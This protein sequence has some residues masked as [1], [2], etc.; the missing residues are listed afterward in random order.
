MA[1][2]TNRRRFLAG[3][4][5][6]G[7]ALTLP[8]LRAFAQDTPHYPQLE[9]EGT[10]VI[11]T[12]G[13]STDERIKSFWMTEFEKEYGLSW[14]TTSY[15][16][17]AK[18]E[19]M[20]RIGNVE[21]DLV[22]L[23]GTQMN[24]AISKDLLRP[25]DYELLYSVVPQ[26]ELNQDV[27]KEYGIGSVAFSTVMG[28]DTDKFE[29]G[30]QTW[31]EFFD[32]E[33]FPGR[34]GLYAQPRPSFEIALMAAGVP[35]EEIYPIDMDE[36]FEAL[37]AI[38]DKVDLWVER[39]SQWG[40]MFQNKEVDLAGASLGRLVEEK[41]NGRSYDFTFAE[42]IV[43]QSYWCIPKNAPA[44]DEAMKALTWFMR[45]PG[46]LEYAKSSPVGMTNITITDDLPPDVAAY[47]P[48]NPV[49]RTTNLYIDDVWWTENAEEAG[50]RWLEW[51]SRS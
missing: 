21:W 2:N 40:V 37:D 23:E 43:E 6:S 39:T 13:G 26:E 44:G 41:I 50:V 3:T 32:T 15:P 38:R 14:E 1:I 22:D 29:T 19:V 31:V 12:W 5:A 18:L 27:C 34:R 7:L 25:I 33:K 45:A 20:D 9:S 48:G 24:L 36:A 49:N 28:W 51:L 17:P 16:D 42:G 4:G 30:P 47:S 10:I 46:Q 11:C 35:R 8:G